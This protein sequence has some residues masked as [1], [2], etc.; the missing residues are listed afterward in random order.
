MTEG[1]KEEQKVPVPV[2]KVKHKT[3]K[4]IVEESTESE[5][6]REIPRRWYIY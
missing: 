1:E 6:Q 2:R 5:K 4:E 3:E